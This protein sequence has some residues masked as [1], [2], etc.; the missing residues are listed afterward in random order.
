MICT[1]FFKCIPK[2]LI[3]CYCKDFCTR[4]PSVIR[5]VKYR[6]LI[7]GFFTEGREYREKFR[8]SIF[9]SF[10]LKNPHFPPTFFI[11]IF[12]TQCP[13]VASPLFYYFFTIFIFLLFSHISLFWWW[14]SHNF[15][16]ANNMGFHTGFLNLYL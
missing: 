15:R 11:F 7:D 10:F 14:F 12:T 5:V 2:C 3:D 1:F 6:L 8:S 4:L 16:P 13:K 9:F